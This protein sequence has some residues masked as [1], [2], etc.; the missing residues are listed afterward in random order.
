MNQKISRQDGEKVSSLKTV[1]S[2][3]TE[4]WTGGRSTVCSASQLP[5]LHMVPLAGLW[6]TVSGHAAYRGTGPLFLP[7]PTSTHLSQQ[8]VSIRICGICC[9]QT[10]PQHSYCQGCSTEIFCSTPGVCYR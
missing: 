5:T 6:R 10:E 2:V 7:G 3:S 4:P 1:L 8:P 9:W